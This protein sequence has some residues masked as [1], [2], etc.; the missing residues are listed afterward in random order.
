MIAE[1]RPSRSTARR[2]VDAVLWL[3]LLWFAAAIVHDFSDYIGRYPYLALDDALVNVSYALAAEGRYGF[4][5]SPTQGMT[6]IARNEGFFNY[7]P[8]YF[9][10]GAGLIHL[11]GYSL[12]LIRSIHLMVIAAGALAAVWWFRRSPLPAAG[13]ACGI[14]L[15]YG[16]DVAQWPMAR[17]DI[18][19]SGFAMATM[20]AAGVAILSSSRA[21]WFAAGLAA[22]CAALTHLIAWTMVP[23]VAAI[24]LLAHAGRLRERDSLA[25]IAAVALGGIASVLMF[26]ASFDFRVV[27]HW[28]SLTAYRDYFVDGESSPRYLAVLLSHLEFAFSFISPQRRLLLGAVLG[29]LSVWALAA[30]ARRPAARLPLM[31]FVAPP[32]IVLAFY[33]A[34]L[35]TY[36]NRHAGYAILIQVTAVWLLA[37]LLSVIPALV[38]RLRAVAVFVL[39]VA[40]AVAAVVAINGKRHRGNERADVSR[41]WVPIADYM[42]AV[43][44]PLPL[45]ARVWGTMMF[46]AET[47]RRVELVQFIDGQRLAGLAPDDVRRAL[48]PEYVIWGY[49]EN[50][51]GLM[52]GLRGEGNQ[53][54]RLLMVAPEWRYR[55]VHMV[56]ARPYGVTRVFARHA[57]ADVMPLPSVDAYDGDGSHWTSGLG[58]ARP[59]TL[60]DADPL[61]L[62][63]GY[64]RALTAHVAARSKRI[65]LPAGRHLLTLTL[66]TDETLGRARVVVATASLAVDEEFGELGPQFD[67][68]LYSA[69]DPSVHLVVN[70]AGGP[71]FISQF[72]ES[73]GADILS[74]TASSLPLLE[75]FS[76]ERLAAT[77]TPMPPPDQWT[78]DTAGGVSVS[79]GDDGLVVTT[80][81]SQFGY[82]LVSPPVDVPRGKPILL[83]LDWTPAGTP[84]CVG[85]LTGDSARWV[86]APTEA[87]TEYR[88]RVPDHDRMVVVF[89]NCRPPNDAA[90]RGQFVVRGAR[91]STQ[92]QEPFYTDLL[93]KGAL[94]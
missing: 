55:L 37:A 78:P 19:V 12:S 93:V 9:W 53:L 81:T 54:E 36:P 67:A 38:P 15:L 84:A 20:V 42:N 61:H 79:P 52:M 7:G 14:G 69:G 90:P 85:V 40:V 34:G 5:A 68:G 92:L 70:H 73:P 30:A 23:A 76:D 91:Y 24:V 45:R 35:G 27:D 75:D 88:F 71:L 22:G 49:P 59:A 51:D 87:R 50:R 43:L 21:A 56:A 16:F 8:W 64:A 48:A 77:L 63:V 46:G 4:L 25:A 89:A 1:P 26:Y 13:V 41:T 80:N 44:A 39:T 82:Q 47:P 3:G 83:R 29:A 74:A 94:R 28:R 58:P 57:P 60:Q 2:L 66:R 6:D 65:D 62:R 11:F 33:V 32:F 18:A 10:L 31:A 86:V 72:D 17:P